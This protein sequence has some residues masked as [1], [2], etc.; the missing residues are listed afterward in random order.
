ML[1][2]VPGLHRLSRNFSRHM[3]GRDGWSQIDT[4]LEARV[5]TD[6]SRG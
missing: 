4:R 3:M 6:N 5:C 1:E 2:I